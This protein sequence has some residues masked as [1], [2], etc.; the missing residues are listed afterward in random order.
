MNQSFFGWELIVVDD[1]SEP[2]ALLPIT[3][4]EHGKKVR[5]VRQKQQG[6]GAARKRGIRDARGSWLCFLDDDDYY[7][8]Q[9]LATLASSI[10]QRPTQLELYLVGGYTKTR[11]GQLREDEATNS[12]H[13]ELIRYWEHPHSLLPIAVHREMVSETPIV[14][15]SSPIEDFEWICQLLCRYPLHRVPASTVVYVEHASNRTNHLVK[16]SSL[17]EREDV[18]GRL[19][20]IPEISRKLG[21]QRISSMLTHQRLHWTRQCIRA[22]QFLDAW[23]GLRRGIASASLGN[24]REVTYTLYIFAAQLLKTVPHNSPAE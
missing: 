15:I 11:G 7:L 20:A 6:P 17:H 21:Q 13:D 4:R 3:D 1:G 9:H 12:E 14:S 8:P 23:Y 16:L 19:T 18:I 22:E 10:S 2:P 24:W 5:L